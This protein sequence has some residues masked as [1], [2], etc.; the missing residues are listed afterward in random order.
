MNDY[1]RE[2]IRNVLDELPG[3]NIGLSLDDIYASLRI[4]FGPLDLVEVK[5][6]VYNMADEQVLEMRS[7]PKRPNEKIYHLWGHRSVN[8]PHQLNIFEYIHM[9]TRAEIE[10]EERQEHDLWLNEELEREKTSLSVLQE[11][12]TGHAREASFAE[13]I[14]KAAPRLAQE[15]PIEIILEMAQWVIDD[16]NRHANDLTSIVRSNAEE[17]KGLTREIGFRRKKAVRFFQRLWRLDEPTDRIGGIMHIPTVSQMTRKKPIKATVDLQLAHDRL[18]ERVIGNHIV[19]VI[20]MPANMHK[21]AIGTDASVGDI[22]V[23]HE[24]GS[25]IP[26][27]PAVLFVASAAMRTINQDTILPYWDFDIEPRDL[28]RYEDMEAA[29]EGLL[30]SPRLRREAITDFRHLRS[31]AMELRQYKEELRVI[32][33]KANWRPIGNIPELDYPPK[34]TLLLRDGRLFPLVHRIDDYDGASAPDDILYGTVVR[35]EIEAFHDVFLKSAGLGRFGPVYGGTVKSPEFSWFSM[36]VFWYLH[37]KCDQKD[38][39]D[40]FYRPI[41]NDQ[42]VT[43]LLFWGLADA[44]DTL[45]DDPRNTFV[46]FRAVRRFSDIAFQSHPLPILDKS[47]DVERL[48][49]EN[50]EDDWI[51]YIEQH[52]Q[53]ADIRYAKLHK[54]GVPSLGSTDAY[55]P[56][57]NLCK[58]SGVAMFYGVPAKMYRPVIESGAH[59]LSP[60]WEIAVDVMSLSDQKLD[61]KVKKMFSWL[62]DE[63]GLVRDE[64]HAVGGFEEAEKGLPLFIPDVVMQAHE[65]V[66]F[67]KQ[68]HV[69]DVE[70]MLRNLIRDIRDGKL[71]SIQS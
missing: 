8:D 29:E 9:K 43:H 11:I 18:K 42:A 23:K 66:V 62:T 60:R 5:Q 3:D 67:T 1:I 58:R 48:L 64:T 17:I 49:D 46:T 59:F 4:R 15:N 33:N 65:T 36:L 44:D 28:E 13:E 39:A 12:A 20:S 10:R 2:N 52:I 40:G 14:R 51:D 35:R 6:A 25:F 55:R 32:D 19:E 21:S 24:Q 38:M 61:E 56:F 57:L 71:P 30:I 27:T 34:I 68:R 22:R 53:D 7:D 26:P 31:A 47:G 16:L 50:N 70:E 37:T 69:P 45:M 54:R 63:G 41:L